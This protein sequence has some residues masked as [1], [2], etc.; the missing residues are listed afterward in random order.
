MKPKILQTKADE[1]ASP[2]GGKT[3]PPEA[4]LEE[5]AADSFREVEP[6]GFGDDP[7]SSIEAA[8]VD[9]DVDDSEGGE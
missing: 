2:G 3:R 6:E 1:T 8:V 7:R 5:E 4:P 9:P